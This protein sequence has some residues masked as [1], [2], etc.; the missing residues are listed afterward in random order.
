MVSAGWRPR[1]RQCSTI[2]I[3]QYKGEEITEL[4]KAVKGRTGQYKI[5]VQ[6]STVKDRIGYP[7]N[8]LCFAQAVLTHKLRPQALP[9][10]RNLAHGRCWPWAIHVATTLDPYVWSSVCSSRKISTRGLEC[11]SHKDMKGEW[12]LL[13]SQNPMRGIPIGCHRSPL[14]YGPGRFRSQSTFIFILPSRLCL[15]CPEC[16]SAAPI[17]HSGQP[18]CTSFHRS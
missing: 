16:K 3:W 4:D 7:I 8:L 1:T 9:Q 15:G 14:T 6:D 12:C 11:V 5:G 13:I 18:F 2:H 17:S 10:T